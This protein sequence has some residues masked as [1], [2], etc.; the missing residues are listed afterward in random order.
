MEGFTGRADDPRAR[1]RTKCYCANRVFE[2]PTRG[3]QPR[4]EAVFASGELE[5]L[6]S[7]AGEPMN[8][9]IPAAALKRLAAADCADGRDEIDCGHA[10]MLYR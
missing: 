1:S 6:R 5:V 8:G 9:R 7:A 4:S 2:E 3:S 10:G